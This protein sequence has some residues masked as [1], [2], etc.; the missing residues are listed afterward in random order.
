MAEQRHLP[1][2][3]VARMQQ[4][5][6]EDYDRFENTLNSASPVSIRL[7][8]QKK[9]KQRENTGKVKWNTN[10]VYLKER[11][12][13]TLDPLFHAGAYYVQEASSMALEY[14]VKQLIG[15]KEHAIKML[16]LCAAPGGKTTLLTQ[17]L[18]PGGLLVANEVINSRVGPLKENIIKWGIPRVLVANHDPK[19]Y[20]NLKGFFD[21]V[22]VDAPCSGEGLFR[23]DPKAVGEWSEKNV[24]LCSARQRRILQDAAPL[25]KPGGFLIYSTCTYNNLENINNAEWLAESVDFRSIKLYPPSDWGLIERTAGAIYG[26][27]FYPH[28]VKGEGFFVAAF[29]KDPE[30]PF[31]PPKEKRKSG[32]ERRFT[33]LPKK[34][35]GQLTEW[36]ASPEDFSFWVTPKEKVVAIPND[37]D[38]EVMLIE[39]ALRKIKLGI[40][41]GTFKRTQF[42]PAH[43]LA[44]S[45]IIRSDLPSIELNR[46]QAIQYLR[47]EDFKTPNLPKGWLLATYQGLNLGWIK[48]LGHRF[49]NYY[50][51]EWRIRMK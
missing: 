30:S 29:Q 46:E 10:G 31:K 43:E 49:N 4:Q 48:E 23:K 38:K 50:P 17:F 21:L 34:L 20:I 41:I 42:I 28:L 18:A 35:S 3:F 22:V 1:S 9:I 37:I 36:I 45:T 40:D 44:L 16:D 11:P 27:Q 24:Q 14:V 33:P 39:G 13:F 25:V 2:P 15:P 51:K 5:L 32:P 12:S 26:Y 8:F 7:H 19:D 6:G 47:K